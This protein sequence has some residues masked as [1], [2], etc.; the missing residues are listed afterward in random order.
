MLVDRPPLHWHIML[1]AV[2]TMS[3]EETT[4]ALKLAAAREC[5]S[6]QRFDAT[7]QSCDDI[8][9]S[10]SNLSAFFSNDLN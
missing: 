3:L 8:T 4:K 5:V 7:M 2:T 1:M 6:R 9:L 10:E